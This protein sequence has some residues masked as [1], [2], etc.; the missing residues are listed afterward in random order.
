M[1]RVLWTKDGNSVEVHLLHK[2]KTVHF[3][4]VAL[5]GAVSTG[6]YNEDTGKKAGGEKRI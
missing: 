1:H 2:G 3:V 5:D 4:K 6:A